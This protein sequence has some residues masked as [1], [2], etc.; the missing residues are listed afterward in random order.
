MFGNIFKMFNWPLRKL[1]RVCLWSFVIV[2]VYLIWHYITTSHN[3][4]EVQDWQEQDQ[5]IEGFNSKGERINMVIVIFIILNRSAAP[6]NMIN[7]LI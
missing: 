7:A 1:K 2:A 4:K 3:F 6:L 5:K